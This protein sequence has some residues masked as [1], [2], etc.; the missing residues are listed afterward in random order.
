MFTST[1]ILFDNFPS[2]ILGKI[3]NK[4][5]KLTVLIDFSNI[6]KSINLDTSPQINSFLFLLIATESTPHNFTPLKIKGITDR[7][8][9]EALRG[10]NLFITRDVLPPALGNEFYWEDLEGLRAESINGDPL[11]NVLSVHDFGAGAMLEVGSSVSETI[12]IPFTEDVVPEV[13]LSNGRV[14]IDAPAG[15]LNPVNELEEKH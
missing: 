12:L 9:A 1:N 2:S 7:D 8:A 5:F 15:L 13:D 14:V 6:L 10:M 3:F 11:G 4:S